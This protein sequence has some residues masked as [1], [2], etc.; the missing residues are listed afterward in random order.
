MNSRSGE[1]ATNRSRSATRPVAA[2]SSGTYRLRVSPTGSVV[3]KMTVVPAAQPGRDRRDRG[4]HVG[5][6]RA[7]GASSSM[8]GTIRTTTSDSRGRRGRRPSSPAGVP[9]RVRRRRARQAPAPRQRGRGPSL[10][11][12][13][14]ASF[15]S[16]AITF[17][18][19]EANWAARGRPILP[20]P[21]TVTVPAVPGSPVQGAT[22]RRRVVAARGRSA[23]RPTRQARSPRRSAGS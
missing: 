1:N 16:T 4:V 12:A 2:S 3:S 9:P 14:T 17:Q 7:G 10:I 5:G 19:C 15:T 11:A 21:T 6:S 18:P 8:T 23:G 22:N 20:A 13:T